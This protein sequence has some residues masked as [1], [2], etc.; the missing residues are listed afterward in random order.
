MTTPVDDHPTT[1]E[2]GGTDVAVDRRTHGRRAWLLVA[3]GAFQLWLWTTRLVNL[4]NDPQPRTAAFVA[5][6]AVLYVAA[7]GTAFVLLGLGWRMRREAS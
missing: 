7:F 2:R 3:L 1:A 5:V 6:H 4:V